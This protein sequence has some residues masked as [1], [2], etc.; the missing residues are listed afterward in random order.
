MKLRYWLYIVLLFM[1]G[2]CAS[3][4]GAMD[5]YYEDVKAKQY[6][7][8]QKKLNNNKLLRHSRNRLMYCM[9]AGKLYHLKKDYKKSNAYLNE[10]DQLAESLQQTVGNIAASHLLNPMHAAYTGEDFEKHMLHYYKAL[11]YAALG[12]YEDAAVEAR[13][14]DLTTQ[15][16]AD[17][18]SNNTNK[19]A[20]DAFALNLQGILFESNGDINNAFISYRNAANLYLEAKGDYYGV[21]MPAQLQ[22][23]LLRTARQL[24]FAGEFEF[25]KNKFGCDLISDDSKQG[26]LILFLEEGHAPVKIQKEYWLNAGSQGRFFYTNNNGLRDHF[27]FDYLRHGYNENQLSSIGSIKI[28]MPAYRVQSGSFTAATVAV[29]GNSYSPAL[30]QNINAVA[31]S[32]LQERFLKEM[33]DALARQLSKKLVEFGAGEIAKGISSKNNHYKSDSSK[34]KEENEQKKEELKNNA[35]MAGAAVSAVAGLFNKM[36]EKADT[37]NWQSLPAFISYVR[38]PLVAGENKISINSRGKIKEFTIHNIGGLQ[39]LNESYP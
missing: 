17:Q 1:L 28:A 7:A 8:A 10:A 19:Y 22:Q 36:T 20:K 9:E 2:S 12:L 30:M 24:G 33:A 14:I 26:S 16:Q 29:N 27:D 5:A 31:S 18:F 13:R 6:D 38:I 15:R 34:T 32:S 25:Y 4:N 3:Y 35:K 39:I 37:R 23:D 11:N 21:P